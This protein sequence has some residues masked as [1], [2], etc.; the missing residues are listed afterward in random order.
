MPTYYYFHLLINIRFQLILTQS[1]ATLQY[2]G[3]IRITYCTNVVVNA[4]LKLSFFVIT[5]FKL[6]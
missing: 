4:E 1:I 2:S 5:K 3:I 6:L